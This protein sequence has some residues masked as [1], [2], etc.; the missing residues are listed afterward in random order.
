MTPGPLTR[1]A[2]WYSAAPSAVAN[3][4][5]RPSPV[6]RNRFND[7][8]G[9]FALRYFAAEPVTALLEAGALYGSYSTGFLPHPHAARPWTVFRYRIARALAVVDFADPG[10]RSGTTTIQELTGDWLGYHDRRLYHH[11]LSPSLPAVRPG[12]NIDA[13][14]QQLAHRLHAI[15]HLAGFLTPAAKAPTIANLVLF[16]HRLDPG[17]ILHTGTA[18]TIL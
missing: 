4:H 8:R 15:P 13:P 3:P 7:A 10:A 5:H 18:T 1:K 16:D 14:T 2:D 11:L 17:T 12:S 6:A 9:A